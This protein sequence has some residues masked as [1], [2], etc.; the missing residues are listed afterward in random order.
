MNRRAMLQ[1]ILAT[2]FEITFTSNEYCTWTNASLIAYKGDT[3]S[4]SSN[5]VICFIGSTNFARWTNACTVETQT[6]Q[7]SYSTPT[8]TGVPNIVT[9]TAIINGS[10]TRTEREYA[11][12]FAN[13]SGG[14]SWDTTASINVP[15]SATIS[16]NGSVVSVNGQSRTYT[17]PPGYQSGNRYYYYYISGWNISNGQQVGTGLTVQP[18]V[19][20]TYTTG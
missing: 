6:D 1:S 13:A 14:G 20:R 4:V 10:S 16:I 5:N 9:S 19:E 15:Y 7:Y 17:V 2:P 8:I 18:S 3:M 11:V 12:N